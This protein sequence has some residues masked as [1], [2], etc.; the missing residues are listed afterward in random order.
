MTCCF[1]CSFKTAAAAAAAAAVFTSR[2]RDFGMDK[3]SFSGDGVVTGSGMIAGRPVF[4][5]SQD[6][7]GELP[8]LPLLP[9]P[10]PLLLVAVVVEAAAGVANPLGEVPSMCCSLQ[11]AFVCSQG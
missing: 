2:C 7:T 6:F 3:S 4:V 11:A 8:L 1:C 10:P 9:L 5:Y